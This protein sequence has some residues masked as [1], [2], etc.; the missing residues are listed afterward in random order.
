MDWLFAD[1]ARLDGRRPWKH[2]LGSLGTRF[3]LRGTSETV[4][5]DSTVEFL[6]TR[7][8]RFLGQ[9][10][11]ESCWGK[12]RK[13]RIR[14]P[15]AFYQAETDQ[16]QPFWCL[17]MVWTS[18]IH[19]HGHPVASD[20]F[21]ARISR[22]FLKFWLSKITISQNWAPESKIGLRQYFIICLDP[23]KPGGNFLKPPHLGA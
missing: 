17:G 6:W 5:I 18:W 7:L 12:M 22:K 20:C 23:P 8:K 16:V 21:T 13:R 4:W 1:L 10:C 9:D 3:S 15:T 14:L 11:Q 2:S 19:P